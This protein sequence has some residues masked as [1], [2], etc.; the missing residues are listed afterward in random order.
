M[1]LSSLTLIKASVAQNLLGKVTVDSLLKE[2]FKSWYKK[3][4]EQ[5]YPTHVTIAQLK[6]TNCKKLTYQLFFGSWCGDSKREVPRMLKLM[7]TLGIPKEQIEL[8]GLDDTDSTLKQSPRGE[9][10]GKHIFRVPALIVMSNNKELGRI[11]EFPVFTLEQD[12]L[13]IISG[14]GYMPNYPAFIDI[15]RWLDNKVFENENVSISGLANGI[16]NKVPNENQLGSLSKLLFMQGR[17]MEAIKIARVNYYLFPEKYAALKTLGDLFVKN[18]EQ[19]KA[20]PVLE[21][22]LKKADVTQ[23][24]DCLKQLYKAKGL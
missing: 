15:S 20:V 8:I 16:R 6:N 13:Q 19:A 24:D 23:F 3:G 12:L 1:L 21:A 11:N 18:N 7:D 5:Y 4:F 17:K 2:P 14:E 10:K 9:E 22:A